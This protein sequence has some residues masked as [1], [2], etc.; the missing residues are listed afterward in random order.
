M[1]TNVKGRVPS[2]SPG[3]G[4]V[5]PRAVA[6]LAVPSFASGCYNEK[7]TAHTP[8]AIDLPI[9]CTTLPRAKDKLPAPAPISWHGPSPAKAG[10]EIHPRAPVNEHTQM[11]K[12]NL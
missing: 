4:C 9:R 1:L 10:K 7:K 11:G 8:Q 2:P 12:L 5:A 6:R 3:L